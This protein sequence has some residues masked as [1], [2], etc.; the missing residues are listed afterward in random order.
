MVAV[1]QRLTKAEEKVVQ[2]LWR[3]GKGK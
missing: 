3:L 1:M 2:V